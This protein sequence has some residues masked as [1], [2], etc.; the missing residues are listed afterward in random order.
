[1]SED[2]VIVLPVMTRL[3]LPPDRILS[4]AKDADLEGCFIIGRTKAG[5]VY[6]GSS[7]ADGGEILWLWE[8]A[9]A[10]LLEGD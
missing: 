3:D 1:M 7:F 10:A 8:K 5:D 6:F 9:K 2:N 4:A